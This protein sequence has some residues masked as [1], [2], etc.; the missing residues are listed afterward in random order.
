[1]NNQ[2]LII[3]APYDDFMKLKESLFLSKSMKQLYFFYYNNKDKYKKYTEQ[4]A[5]IDYLFSSMKFC[6]VYKTLTTDKEKEDLKNKFY[7][8][9]NKYVLDYEKHIKEVK[10]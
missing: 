6:F 1:M 9:Q 2:D 7:D 8:Y 10:K 5:M 3:D 4:R